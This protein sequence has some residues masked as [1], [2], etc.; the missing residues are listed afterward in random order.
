MKKLVIA[1]VVIGLVGCA[2]A[3]ANR[4]IGQHSKTLFAEYGPPT[5]ILNLEDETSVWIYSQ[6]NISTNVP[7]QTQ[8]P[9]YAGLS[10]GE[11]LA[12]GFASGMAAGMNQQKTQVTTSHLMFWL[13]EDN[14]VTKWSRARN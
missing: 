2:A 10:V 13:D 11:S 5:N 3:R 14:N 7:Y 8:A 6:Q 9:S 1:L 4:M 12:T